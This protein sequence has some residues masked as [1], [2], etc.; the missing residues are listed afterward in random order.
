LKLYFIIDVHTMAIIN[1]STGNVV[2]NC[3]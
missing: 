3:T 1:W 2:S